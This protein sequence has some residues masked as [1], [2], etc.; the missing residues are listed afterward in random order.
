MI[1]KVAVPKTILTV[2]I[3]LFLIVGVVLAGLAVVPKYEPER[4]NSSLTFVYGPHDNLSMSGSSVTVNMSD[5]QGYNGFGI[6]ING[7]Y[8]ATDPLTIDKIY[9]Y[10][11]VPNRLFVDEYT[12]LTERNITYFNT[13]NTVSVTPGPLPANLLVSS[14]SNAEIT[15]SNS[16]FNNSVNG[17]FVFNPNYSSELNSNGPYPINVLSQY[18]LKFNDSIISGNRPS[19]TYYTVT[20]TGGPTGGGFLVLNFSYPYHYYYTDYLSINGS[21]EN[22]PAINQP[23]LEIGNFETV[24]L[25]IESSS[26]NVLIPYNYV[27]S[28][29]IPESYSPSPELNF[30]SN[31]IQLVNSSGSVANING[32]MLVDA[33][34]GIHIAMRNFYNNSGSL[35]LG[36]Y[37]NAQNSELLLNGKDI[38]TIQTFWEPEGFRTI[39]DLVAGSFFGVVVGMILDT[40]RKKN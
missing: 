10:N 8:G 34:G 39:S 15:I 21:N 16:V 40:I 20:L 14:F 4:S 24:V 6:S 17:G 1:I 37:A 30:T 28:I 29:D 36:V 23:T 26:S 32:N 18:Y 19:V 27:K 7:T 3:V 13:G 5:P 11:S 2:A 38:S 25:Q 35:V 31:Q 9:A 22:L 33:S 12:N